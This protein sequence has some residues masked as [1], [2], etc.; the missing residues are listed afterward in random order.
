M[1]LVELIVVGTASFVTA[2][3]TFFSGFGLGTLLLPVFALFLPVPVAV[4][5]TAVVHLAN[6]L[7]KAGIIGKYVHWPT[8][9]RFGVPAVLLAF[10]GAWLLGWL[11]QQ[12]MVLWRYTLWDQPFQITTLKLLVGILILGFSLL[13]LVPSFSQWQLGPKWLPVGGALSGFFGGLSGHQGAFRSAFLIRVGLDK[14]AFIATAS[15]AAIAVDAARLTVYGVSFYQERFAE[16][17][18]HGLLV[19]MSVLA[20]LAGTLIGKKLLAK[21]TIEAIHQLVGWLL[22]LS[23]IALALG[24]I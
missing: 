13:E 7:F 3:L 4:A 17:G 12:E 9:W 14:Q 15:M 16:V 22:V 11:G 20:A 6:N 2:G 24:W 1:P 5:A 23:G 19:G 8:L 18:Q 21:T 10:A